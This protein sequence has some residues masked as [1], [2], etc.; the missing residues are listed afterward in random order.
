MIYHLTTSLFTAEAL[1][2]IKNF[3][4]LAREEKGTKHSVEIEYNTYH[5]INYKGIIQVR[6]EGKLM[7]K[8]AAHIISEGEWNFHYLNFFRINLTNC[9]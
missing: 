1:I 5:L 6:C 7:L 4:G 9:W 2:S 8:T 3:K